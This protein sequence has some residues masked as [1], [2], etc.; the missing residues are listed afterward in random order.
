[1][2][3]EILYCENCKQ[4]FCETCVG[5]SRWCSEE[6][7]KIANHEDEEEEEEEYNSEISG[8]TRWVTLTRE[9]IKLHSGTTGNAWT[10]KQLAVL[11]VPWPPPKGW[12]NSL[13]GKKISIEDA[14]LFAAL[15]N[16]PQPIISLAVVM[17]KE[18]LYWHSDC[19]EKIYSLDEAEREVEKLRVEAPGVGWAYER[20][21]NCKHH[22]IFRLPG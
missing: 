7:E 22:H 13:I 20:C 6:C 15:Q 21:D 10:K 18:Q 14:K 4:P 5:S 3:S 9:F 1:M 19:I 12:L 8:G 11:R 16:K 2:S 17:E